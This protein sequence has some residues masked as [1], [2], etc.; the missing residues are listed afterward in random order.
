[1]AAVLEAVEAAQRAAKVALE[2]AEAA[3]RSADAAAMALANDMAGKKPPLATPA[4]FADCALAAPLSAPA[5]A[6]KDPSAFGRA[7]PRNCEPYRW[8]GTTTRSRATH[9]TTDLTWP[10][11]T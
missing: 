8:L 2:A 6:A 4:T 3:T 5:S 10:L 7:G 9:A 11:S 1:M